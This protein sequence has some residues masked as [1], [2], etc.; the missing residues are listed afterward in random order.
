MSNFLYDNARKHFAMGNIKWKTTGGDTFR[1]F[2]LDASYT[3]DQVTHETL[4]DIASNLR[5]GR[6]N[7]NTHTDGFELIINDPVGGI[8]DAQ[9]ITVTGLPIG[10]NIGHV[11]VYK[12]GTSDA[13]SLLLSLVNIPFVTD[14]RDIHIE[15]NNSPTK[16]FRV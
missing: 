16:L 10:L 5:H 14:N 15:W 7:L 13:D 2:F 12:E 8:C 11:L 6:D 1:F 4:A 3:P 9:D